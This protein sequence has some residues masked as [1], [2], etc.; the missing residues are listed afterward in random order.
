VDAESRQRKGL[1]TGHTSDVS[2]VS[3]SPDGKTLASGSV[4]NTIRLWDA[5]T[6]REKSLLTRHTSSV[7]SVSFSPDGETLASGSVDNTIRLWDLSFLYDSRP[8]E[9]KIREAE[10]TFNLKL[11]NLELQPI[12]P[13]R[14]LYGVSSRPPK[15]PETHP[16][17]WLSEAESGSAEA[18]V[19][20][21]IIYDR[22]NELEKGFLWYARAVEAGSV[23]GKERMETFRR[24]LADHKDEYPEMYE[25]C[26]LTG[27]YDNGFQD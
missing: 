23:R 8:A 1:L 13:E 18:M 14:N 4:D 12:P 10:Q 11:V 20:L 2:S 9:E 25:K 15:W 22:D 27:K 16:F 6:G 26:C 19:R 5:E 3:F 17:R 21:G 24:W 7:S